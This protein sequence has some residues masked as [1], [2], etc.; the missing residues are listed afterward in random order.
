MCFTCC[1]LT[2]VTAISSK[3]GLVCPGVYLM[4]LILLCYVIHISF[5]SG[6]MLS[7]KC[8]T[9]SEIIRHF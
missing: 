8:N 9:D 5:G 6:H 2:Q 7:V 4:C 1:E 3:K